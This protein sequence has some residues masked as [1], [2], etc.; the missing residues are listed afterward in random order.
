MFHGIDKEAKLRARHFEAVLA[1]S[2]SAHDRVI[3]DLDIQGCHAP[4]RVD[5][6]LGSLSG[7]KKGG[8]NQAER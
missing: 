2:M 6:R 7:L 4:I 8:Q 3:S 5:L 1:D